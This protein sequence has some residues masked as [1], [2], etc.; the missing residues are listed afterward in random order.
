MRCHIGDVDGAEREAAGLQTVVVTGDAVAVEEG[1]LIERAGGGGF[2]RGLRG[3]S[4]ECSRRQEDG[5]AT[6]R[7]HECEARTL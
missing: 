3:G 2:T 5:D 7:R 4:G 6:G 1:L